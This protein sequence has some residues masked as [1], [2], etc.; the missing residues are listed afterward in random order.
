MVLFIGLSSK[1]DSA[2]G[3]MSSLVTFTTIEERKRERKGMVLTA[4]TDIRIRSHTPLQHATH[5]PEPVFRVL[6]WE[7]IPMIHICLELICV[8]PGRITVIK[9]VM[10]VAQRDL[11]AMSRDPGLVKS[12]CECFVEMGILCCSGSSWLHEVV[13]VCL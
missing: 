3:Y 7:L 5:I 10:F 1:K 9:C 4:T 2:V 13:D 8:S 6:V 11:F 12:T